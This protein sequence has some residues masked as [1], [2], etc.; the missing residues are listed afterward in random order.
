MDSF[1]SCLDQENQIVSSDLLR[2]AQSITQLLSRIETCLGPVIFTE[3]LCAMILTIFG[4]FQATNGY[5]ALTQPSFGDRELAKLLLGGT[6]VAVGEMS[7]LR[8]IPFY[9]VGHG[10]T[11]KMKQAKYAIEEILA[12]RYSQFSPIQHQQFDVVRENWSRSAALQPMGLFDLNYSTAIAM[13]GLL[14]T[15]IVI[16]IQ[17]K[18]G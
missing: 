3:T 18:M 6:F 8:Y 5:L 9:H 12:K 17:F 16:L 11:L 1:N 2:K 10:I 14:I 4:I 7:S 15:Y 13:D